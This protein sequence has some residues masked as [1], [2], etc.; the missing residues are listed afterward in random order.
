[1]GPLSNFGYHLTAAS[2]S[3]LDGGR[4]SLTTFG[5]AVL[6]LRRA[7]PQFP[8]RSSSGS[9]EKVGR[10]CFGLVCLDR[11]SF[12]CVCFQDPSFSALL[13]GCI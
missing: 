1:M 13:S 8:L 4:R 2:G 12:G 7:P 11:V 10:V 5:D 9:K 3:Y 6:P